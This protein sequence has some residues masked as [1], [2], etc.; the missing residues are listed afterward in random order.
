MF[1]P[2][3][4][5]PCFKTSQ[6]LNN[7]FEKAMSEIIATYYSVRQDEEMVHE[8]E[9]RPPIDPLKNRANIKVFVLVL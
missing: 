4:I 5:I 3:S 9:S 6:C 7:P 2:T 1:V 8:G